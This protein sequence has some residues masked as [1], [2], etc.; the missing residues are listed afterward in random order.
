MTEKNKVRRKF[1]KEQKD[2]A[3]RLSSEPGRSV[4]QVADELGCGYSSLTKWR[5][6]RGAINKQWETLSAEQAQIK[7][8]QRDNARLEA[9]NSFLKKAATFFASQKP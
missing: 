3:V 4:Q 1:T 5:S 8:L 9:E 6:E 7:K 2:E